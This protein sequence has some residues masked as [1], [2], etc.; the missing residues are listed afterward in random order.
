MTINQIKWIAVIT[1]TIDH[2]GFFLLNETTDIYLMFRTIGRV[3]FPL[4]AFMIAE[5]YFHTRSK[6]KYFIRLLMIGV[7]FEMILIGIY[8]GYGVNMTHVPFLTNNISKMNIMWTLMLGFIGIFVMDKY[9]NT[10]ILMLIPLAIV[11]YYSAY[12]F[13][14]F[15]LILIF[16]IFKTFNQRALYGSLLTLL[17]C[18]LPAISSG[19]DYIN[20]IQTISI[21]SFYII[22]YYNGQKGKSNLKFLYIYY[23]L[24]I[25]LLFFLSLIL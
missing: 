19:I 14:G 18:F 12:S 2:I 11:S 6:L 7:I 13:Y 1:M 16:G 22:K 4:F 8:L 9:K 5:G 17:Y 15:G 24:H 3:A 10:G 23:P 20:W 25:I 21:F